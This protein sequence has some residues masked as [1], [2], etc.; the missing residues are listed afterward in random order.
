MNRKLVLTILFGLVTLT[1]GL[2]AWAQSARSLEVNPSE[3]ADAVRE[4]IQRAQ[5]VKAEAHYNFDTAIL[6]SVYINDPR[7]GQ[8]KPGAL[9]A[10]REA[11]QDP[12]LR[13]DEV[14]YLD[15]KQAIVVNMEREYEA[16]LAELARKEAAGT[17]TNDEKEVLIY[18]RTGVF[19]HI[20]EP[21][22]DMSGFLLTP[23]AEGWASSPPTAYP[24]PA[25]PAYIPPTAT[26]PPYPVPELDGTRFG[27]PHRGT[28]PALLRDEMLSIDVLSVKID[29]DVAKAITST[30]AI[31]TEL[32]LVKVDG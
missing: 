24:L 12:G 27:V 21:T 6:A 8:M 17:L 19:T 15:Y 32:T 20:P 26:L 7:G 4:V 25:A 22:P 2:F 9:A 5:R 18:I 29:G 1:L 23:Q 31:I 11:R 16:Y 3:E 10:V 13:A 30:P 28:D 14:G